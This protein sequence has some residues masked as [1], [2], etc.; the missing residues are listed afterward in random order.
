M[1]QRIKHHLQIPRPPDPEKYGYRLEIDGTTIYDT[2]NNASSGRPK[3][4][5]IISQTHASRLLVGF[6]KGQPTRGQVARAYLSNIGEKITS[7]YAYFGGFEGQGNLTKQ[8]ILPAGIDTVQS[9]CLEYDAGAGF[10]LKID[11]ATVSDTFPESPGNME[12]EYKCVTNPGAYIPPGYGGLHNFTLTFDGSDISSQYIGGGYIKVTY[13]T[14]E[15]SETADNG[16]SRYYFPGIEGLINLYSSLYVPGISLNTMEM[17]LRFDNN[18]TT[19]L[20]IGN[21]EVFDTKDENSRKFCNITENR[22]YTCDFSNTN[23]SAIFGGYP[24]SMAQNTI[25]LRMGVRDI[26]TQIAGIDSADV[27]LITDLSGSMNDAVGSNNPG[28]N[29]NCLDPKLYNDTTSRIALAKCLDVQFID[30]ILNSSINA[31][32]NRVGLVGFT[33]DADTYYVPLTRDNATLKSEVNDY[34]ANGGTCVCCA[35]NRATQLLNAPITEYATLVNSTGWKYKAYSDCGDNCDPTTVSGSCN[36]TSGNWKALSYN[37]TL[38]GTTNLP[39]NNDDALD[40]VVY[41]RRYFNI[42]SIP[43]GNI[44]LTVRNKKGLNA[45]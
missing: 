18:Y 26:T 21:T 13:N 6:G 33:T 45:T 12:A 9:I 14:S 37:D 40:T 7:T 34:T 32:N 2:Q 20:N 4:N 39:Y 1:V 15:F 36:I 29:R 10:H 22:T 5:S 25:P 31:T 43:P 30:Q 24:S 19:Y 38:W 27:V 16:T 8:V 35:I 17:H 11:G 41:F 23:L 28:T 3:N 42:S 44:T